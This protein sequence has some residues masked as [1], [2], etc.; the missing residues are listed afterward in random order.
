LVLVLD[1]Q[2]HWKKPKVSRRN[3]PVMIRFQMKNYLLVLIGEMLTATTSPVKLEIKVNAAHAT[4]SPS[5]KLWNQNSE[6]STVMILQLFP[7]N[8]FFHATI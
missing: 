3:T 8:K 5:F 2:K 6:S 1:G 4:Q 7:F